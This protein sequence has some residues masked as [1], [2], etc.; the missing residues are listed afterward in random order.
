VVTLLFFQLSLLAYHQLTTLVDLYPF[1]GAS[2]YTW[3]EKLAECSV[4]GLL[5]LPP[6]DF[7]F[8]IRVLMIFGRM[9]LV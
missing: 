8:Q 7:G 9:S 6:I 1:N 3:K 2:N 4:N 5:L